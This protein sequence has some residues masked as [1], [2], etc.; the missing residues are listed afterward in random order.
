[1]T[2]QR[3]RAVARSLG[4]RP[5]ATA[6]ALRTGEYRAIS[7]IVPDA[8]WGWWEPVVRAAFKAAAEVGY[9]LMAHPVAGTKG[10]AAAIVEA[11][12][13]VPT[14]GVI[15]IGVPDQDG[16]CEA[17][18]RIALPAIAIDDTSRTVR[19]PTISAQNREGARLAVEHLISLG[20]RSIALLRPNIGVET[21]NWGDGLFIDHRT[22]GYRDALDSAG[23]AFNE[24][25]IIDCT[26]PFNETRKHWRELE[27]ELSTGVRID[28]MFCAA[29]TMAAAALRTLRAHGLKVPEDVSIVGFDDERAAILVDPQLTTIRQPY[30]E[31][32]CYAVELLLRKIQGEHVDIRRYEFVTELVR[33]SSTDE[34]ER[35]AKPDGTT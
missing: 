17:C 25:L 31:M 9:Y 19:F 18:D 16:V 6:R 32:G 27:A 35:L 30:E 4:Y 3:V 8:G 21:D 24:S 28:A 20:R 13:N 11:L 2:R 22:L 33:R 23:I 15:V 14:D 7:V 5:S 26:D 1:M 29:D 34:P 12:A 10:G